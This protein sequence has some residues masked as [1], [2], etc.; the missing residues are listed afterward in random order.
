MKLQVILLIFAAIFGCQGQ[1][2]V[3]EDLLEAQEELRV[4]HEFAEIFLVDNRRL[5][6]D[7]LERIEN[8]TL[9]EF[10]NAYA[11]IKTIGLETTAEMDAFEEPSFCKD[12]IRARWVL[13]VTRYGQKISR[14]L[15]TTNS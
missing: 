14:C 8:F 1:L 4:G 13:Q 2:T 3:T 11:A 7:Y 12:A 15:A 9:N 6:S 10:M 5:L